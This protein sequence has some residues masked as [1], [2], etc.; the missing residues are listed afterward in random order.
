MT[1][2]TGVLPHAR[3]QKLSS[4]HRQIKIDLI[5][6]VFSNGLKNCQTT[7]DLLTVVCT[8]VTLALQTRSFISTQDKWLLLILLPPSF[9]SLLISLLVLFV[10]FSVIITDFLE[11]T[12]A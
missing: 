3:N 8:G 12:G 10:R 6:C 9:G 5:C 11:R 2:E 7:V 1:I 4:W